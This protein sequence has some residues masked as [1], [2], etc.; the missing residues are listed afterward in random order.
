VIRAYAPERVLSSARRFAGRCEAGDA[1]TWDGVRFAFLHPPPD[2]PDLDNDSSCVLRVEG[3][4][5]SALLPGDV[6]SRVEERL[7]R[8][9]PVAL[10]AGVL[11]VPHHGSKSSSSDAFLAAVQPRHAL[12]SAGHRNRFGHPTPE[13]LARLA[14]HGVSVLGTAD[15]GMLRVTGGP[16]GEETREFRRTRR[17]WWHEAH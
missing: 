11:V 2:F 13:V 14:A 12:V 17:R 1:W 16:A 10:R 3:A 5:G 6:S 8:E 7:V 9:Q 15:G 4:Y